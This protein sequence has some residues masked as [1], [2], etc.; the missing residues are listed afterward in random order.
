MRISE[1]KKLYL[2]MAE[3]YYKCRR[4]KS[5][6]PIQGDTFVAREKHMIETSID[7]KEARY[8]VW[9]C[10]KCGQ[11]QKRGWNKPVDFTGGHGNEEFKEPEAIDFS[12]HYEMQMQQKEL[13]ERL[14]L[15]RTVLTPRKR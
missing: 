12:K 10:R 4:C 7:G 2:F 5:A 11:F 6:E 8:V 1:Y 9:R 3:T 13:E 15:G 14:R